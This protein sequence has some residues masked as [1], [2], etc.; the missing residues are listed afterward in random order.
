M[1]PVPRSSNTRAHG[2]PFWHA[3]ANRQRIP[4]GRIICPLCDRIWPIEFETELEM[5][6]IVPKSEGGAYTRENC[7]L[8]CPTCNKR[9]GEKSQAEGRAL[10]L[11]A[12]NS[13][14]Y[15]RNLLS[16]STT[17]RRV[18]AE[19]PAQAT[20]DS[21][22]NH[23]KHRLQDR[24]RAREYQRGKRKGKKPRNNPPLFEVG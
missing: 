12:R 20:A 9:K 22:K 4:D 14:A 8:T 7:Q 16:K 3:V 1:A 13:T 24:A 11:E 19:N 17:K 6:R 23:A 2:S 21:R 5:D 15:D 10:C 18:R